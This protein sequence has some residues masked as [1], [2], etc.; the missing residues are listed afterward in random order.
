MG[1]LFTRLRD[2]LYGWLRY[3][4][5]RARLFS[6]PPILVHVGRRFENGAAAWSLHYRNGLILTLGDAGVLD[7]QDPRFAHYLDNPRHG[8]REALVHLHRVILKSLLK[9]MVHG[10]V[11]PSQRDQAA[12]ATAMLW[13]TWED[14]RPGMAA[15]APEGLPISGKSPD[16]GT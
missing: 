11:E 14:A 13:M 2:Q 6:G 16:P 9:Y 3:R 5:L 12:A 4:R 1:F 8:G 7:Y 10:K 15:P